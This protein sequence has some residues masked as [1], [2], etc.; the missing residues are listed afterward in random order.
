MFQVVSNL[1]FFHVTH[2]NFILVLVT[3]FN[4]IS[5]SG[6]KAQAVI[7]EQEVIDLQPSGQE[8]LPE[9]Q[10]KFTKCSFCHGLGH[11]R[12]T[13][14]TW[15][16]Q[17]WRKRKAAMTVFGPFPPSKGKMTRKKEKVSSSN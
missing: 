14:A 16:A 1:G 9:V 2:D 6:D 15:Q 12:Q 8:E 7:D 5:W 13:C 10:K 11:N 17:A 4:F 3:C